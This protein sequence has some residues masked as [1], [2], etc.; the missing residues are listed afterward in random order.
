MLSNSSNLS[1]TTK[2][3]SYMKTND[4]TQLFNNQI[5][6]LDS[7]EAAQYLRISAANLRVKVSRGEILV[8]G[9]L[10]R[11]LRFRRE[12]LDRLLEVSSK[13]DF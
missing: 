11:T 6:W 2:E 4:R 1:F 5:V 3:I 9:R 13:G 10:G 7:K 12:E 8:N